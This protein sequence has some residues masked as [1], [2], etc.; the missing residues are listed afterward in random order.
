MAGTESLLSSLSAEIPVSMT[1]Q[2]GSA[3]TRK[4]RQRKKALAQ[5]CWLT[6]EL[7]SD[8]EETSPESG[9]ASRSHMLQRDSMT[10]LYQD[11]PNEKFYFYKC[12]VSQEYI[13]V[14]QQHFCTKC[15]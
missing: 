15:I 11:F 3:V 9:Y 8:R 1:R 6:V 5:V 7:V 14:S 4:L 10:L 12:S 2:S 13:S